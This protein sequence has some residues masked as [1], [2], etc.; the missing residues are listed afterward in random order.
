MTKTMTTI[1]L[2]EKIIDSILGASSEG[3]GE[4]DIVRKSISKIEKQIFDANIKVQ[5]GFCH[6]KPYALFVNPQKLFTKTRTELGDYLFVIKYLDDGKIIDKRA[7]FFQAKYSL[8][9]N[10]FHIE[11]HQFHFYSQIAN[12]EFKFGNTVYKDLKTTPIIWKSI[13]KP[14]EFGDYMMISPSEVTD[15]NTNEIASQYIH[16]KSGYFT[17]RLSLLY[18][19]QCI[20]GRGYQK[21]CYRYFNPLFDFLK[22]FGKGNKIEGNFETFVDLIYKKL[23]MIPDPPEEHEGFWEEGNNGGFGLIE[24]TINNN[25]FNQE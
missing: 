20:F 5:A 24:I 21:Y 7:L 4:V 13:S 10:P 18:K 8:N 15:L 6:Q 3:N 9:N 16:K 12:L 22:P 23:E 14:N 1:E 25:E 17:Y 19:R 11:L 2:Y